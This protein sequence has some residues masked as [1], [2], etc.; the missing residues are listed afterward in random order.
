MSTN[1]PLVVETEFTG[2]A[3]FAA[4]GQSLESNA[5]SLIF[6]FLDDSSMATC[7]SSVGNLAD[8][9]DLMDLHLSETFMKGHNYHLSNALLNEE[10]SQR[11]WRM[12][13]EE[14]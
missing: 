12:W 7:S 8:L 9:N 4:F 1:H 11:V 13:D 10:V 14:I 5:V 2:M 3:V 6:S